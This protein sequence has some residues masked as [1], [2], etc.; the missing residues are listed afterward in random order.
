MITWL[1]N[2][3]EKHR[4]TPQKHLNWTQPWNQIAKSNNNK[5]HDDQFERN[6][7]N[8]VVGSGVGWGGGG[9]GGGVGVE[10]EVQ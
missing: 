1:Q 9:E 10:Q 7:Q 8:V 3:L 4:T 2:V 5:C 6:E